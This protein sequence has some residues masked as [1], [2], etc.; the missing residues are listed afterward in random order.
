MVSLVSLFRTWSFLI[1]KLIS[2]NLVTHIEHGTHQT[3][4]T[5]HTNHINHTYRF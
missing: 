5:F 4:Q 1:K 2:K 3:N